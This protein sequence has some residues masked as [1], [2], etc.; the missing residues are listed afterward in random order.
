MMRVLG[1]L[2]LLLVVVAAIGYHQGWFI[3][4]SH[5]AN[6]QHTVTLTVDKNKIDQDGAR[7]KQ[8]VEDLAH[9]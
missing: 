6:G 3:A 2:V 1:E 7:A 4:E 9:Q 5:D 8:Q